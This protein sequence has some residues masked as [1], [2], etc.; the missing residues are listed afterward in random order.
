M[1]VRAFYEGHATE[2]VL[3]EKPGKPIRLQCRFR[4]PGARAFLLSAVQQGGRPPIVIMEP[5]ASIAPIHD[6]IPLVF[7]PGESGVWL[8]DGFEILAN[9][10]NVQ[11]SVK[12]ED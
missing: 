12:L 11:L 7:G 1:P 3:G 2:K 9:R 8:G 5:N 6:R 4:P 10:G